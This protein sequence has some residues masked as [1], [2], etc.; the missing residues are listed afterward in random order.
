[1]RKLP[2]LG[3]ITIALVAAGCG[4]GGSSSNNGGGGGGGGGGTA[5]IATPGPPNVEALIVDA[6]PPI[7]TQNNQPAINTAFITVQVCV[8]PAFSTCQTFDHIEIDTG[9]VGLRILA[10]AADTSGATFNLALPPVA[11]NA[12]Q[13]LAECLHFADGDSWGSVNTANISLPISG[14]KSSTPFN[15]HVIGASSAG[16]PPPD[17]IPSPSPP[18]QEENTV[19]SF[20]ANGILGVGPFINDCNPVGSCGTGNAAGYFSCTT[21]APVTCTALPNPG[22]SLAQQIPNPVTLFAKDNNGIIIEL[23]AAANNGAAGLKNGA[24]V[25][26][27]GTEN[28][29]ALGSAVQLFADP[30]Q[31]FISA[32][33]DGKSY[34]QSYLDSG[35]NGNFYSS[36]ITT[37]PSPNDVWY[38]PSSTVNENATLQGTNGTM[39]AAPFNVAN[40]D[41]LFMNNPTFTVFPELAGPGT[42]TAQL[43]SL[44]FGL[45]FFFGRN[46]YTAIE[47]PTTGSA[48]YFAYISN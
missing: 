20:G 12:G 34:P 8:P 38:C 45:P 43:C 23:P 13:V 17:C 48:P 40:A 37:C 14:E 26:G 32:T 7:L 2:T 47:D 11:G 27:I 33:L 9:S 15:V 1:V 10:D 30:Q 36:S 41:T 46:V 39:G 31:G 5:T 25:F 16:A 35:S 44:D 4:G 28:N 19:L 6:G 21:T 42:C 22:A 24:L 3:L 29:N 18:L